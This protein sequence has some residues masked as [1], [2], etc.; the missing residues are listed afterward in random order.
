[1]H[2]VAD[3]I[4]DR[5]WLAVPQTTKRQRIENEIDPA[6][7]SAWSHFIKMRAMAATSPNESLKIPLSQ[8]FRDELGHLEHTH[9]A[10]TIKYRP[11]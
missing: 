6:P 3:C 9:L 4:A 7:I 11:E 5:I 2:R 8:M 1:V 10:L